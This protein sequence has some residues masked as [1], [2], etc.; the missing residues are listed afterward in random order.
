MPLSLYLSHLGL[1][2]VCVA[3]SVSLLLRP[4]LEEW[5]EDY[6]KVNW[7]KQNSPFPPEL[8]MLSFSHYVSAFVK[9]ESAINTSP[10]KVVTLGLTLGGYAIDF[11]DCV[12]SC[13]HHYSVLKIHTLPC[14]S[15]LHFPSFC[16]LA[17]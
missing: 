14:A 6:R 12:M 3:F 8:Y 16:L 15:V 1:P 10:L 4:V 7:K 5:C 11:K 2:V 9:D 13:S 17:P